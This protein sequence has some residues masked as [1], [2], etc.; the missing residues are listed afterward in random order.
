M[1]IDSLALYMTFLGLLAA[2]YQLRQK[3]LQ[4]RMVFKDSIS[5]EYFDITFNL[6]SVRL[7][8]DRL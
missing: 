3:F 6:D 7:Q 2:I 5:K 8:V 4:Q 1:N